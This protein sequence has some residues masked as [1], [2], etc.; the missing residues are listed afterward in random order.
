[1]VA[2]A[3]LVVFI[4][5]GPQFAPLDR[6]D[7]RW[8]AILI[9]ALIG[10]MSFPWL[11]SMPHEIKG[12][13]L[14]GRIL[15]DLCSLGAG[16]AV[17][18]W[19]R[20]AIWKVSITVT[21]V[22]WIL[23]SF[24]P[25]LPFLVVQAGVVLTDSSLAHAADDLLAMLR[26]PIQG[27]SYGKIFGT[28]PE[29]SMLADQLLTLWI[30]FALASVLLGGSLFRSRLLGLRIE[31]LLLFS[32]LLALL[33][34]QS[35]IGLIAMAFMGGS[36]WLAIF[37]SRGG[38]GNLKLLFLPLVLVFI[39]SIIAATGGDRLQS[40]IDSFGGVDS[41]IDEGVWSNVTRM[42]T[43][44]SGLSMATSYP[45]G[46]GTG[47]FPYMF[48]QSV[49]EWG[50]ISPEIRALLSGDT[51]YLRIATGTDGGDIVSRLPDA[52]ALPIRVLAELG[53]PGFFLLLSIWTGLVGGCW[54]RFMSCQQA[55]PLKLV[56]LGVLLSLLAMLPLSFSINSYVW[57]HWILIA[58]MAAR[59]Y[60]PR[61]RTNCRTHTR[62][63][64]LRA[65]A[66]HPLT[67]QFESE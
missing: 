62:A 53:L 24:S 40:F 10:D 55:S 5:A 59:L 63:E 28:A 42:A 17:W 9:W 65:P 35:R 43:I 33:L 51:E 26:S 25:V 18:F 37:K 64:S 46:V 38:W 2:L 12:Q 3:L 44:T 61:T 50:L 29:A 49:P 1:M 31:V 45:M 56:S 39:G 20:M 6:F 27:K 36:A 21:A 60:L 4:Q 66:P 16:M 15:R 67:N 19:F 23:C 8:L 22:R 52:K 13:S 7:R 34:S 47:A 30:P 48:E 57:V 14:E 41:S 32:T 58:A 11:L 54:R